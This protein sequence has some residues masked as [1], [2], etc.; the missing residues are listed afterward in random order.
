M[1]PRTKSEGRWDVAVFTFLGI[2]PVGD[3]PFAS[4]L[5]WFS[6]TKV[7]TLKWNTDSR[8]HI[9]S[10]IVRTSLDASIQ[11][12]AICI[13]YDHCIVVACLSEVHLFNTGRQLTGRNLREVS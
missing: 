8:A 3:V 11:K 13:F 2:F 10:F 7:G 6:P 5:T 1:P 12:K 4:F 9:P